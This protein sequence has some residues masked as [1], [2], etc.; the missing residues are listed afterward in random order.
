M[1]QIAEMEQNVD[2]ERRNLRHHLSRVHKLLFGDLQRLVA[3]GR[4]QVDLLHEL[5]VGQQVDEGREVGEG[6]EAG[7]AGAHFGRRDQVAFH[8]LGQQVALDVHDDV[9]EVVEADEARAVLVAGPEGHRRVLLVEIVQELREFGVGDDAILALAKVQLD[10]VRVERER[11]LLVQVRLLD[12]GAKLLEADRPISIRIEQLKGRS[13]KRVGHA[14]RAFEGLKFGPRN[15]AVLAR[16]EDPAEDL[17]RLDVKI[18][19][20]EEAEIADEEIFVG[21]VRLV[22]RSGARVTVEHFAQRRR[23]GAFHVAQILSK[24]INKLVNNING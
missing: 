13:I 14:Q 7:V 24:Q 3:V 2:F 11:D 12:D 1:Q 18:F 23:I 15:Q 10:E 9:V 19:F 17:G 21:H 22:V 16:V 8:G 5:D 6:D 20:G 4:V